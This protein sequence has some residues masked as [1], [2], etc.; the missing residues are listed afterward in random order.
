MFHRL[1]DHIRAGQR[2][3]ADIGGLVGGHPQGHLV[4]FK[5][6]HEQL[7]RDAGDFLF[8]DRNDLPYAMGG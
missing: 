2:P 3:H 6:D 5:G 4:L 1:I 7:Q 8:F